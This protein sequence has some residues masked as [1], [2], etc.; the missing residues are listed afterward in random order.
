MYTYRVGREKKPTKTK[1]MQ[2]QGND[3]KMKY[4]KHFNFFIHTGGGGGGVE[5]SNTKQKGLTYEHHNH[6]INNNQS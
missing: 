2:K 5:T 3:K 1:I 6:K 4:V